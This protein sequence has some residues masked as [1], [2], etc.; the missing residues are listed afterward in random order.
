[1][2]IWNDIRERA[3][4]NVEPTAPPDSSLIT[5]EAGQQPEET[6]NETPVSEPTPFVLFDS[7]PETFEDVSELDWYK[8]RYSEAAQKLSDPQFYDSILERYGE[9]ILKREQEAEEIIASFKALKTNPRDFV[10]QYY[11]ESLAEIGISPVLSPEEMQEKIKSDLASEFGED[12]ESMYDEKDLAPWKGQTFS[13]RI[14]DRGNEL[15]DRYKSENARSQE[16]FDGYAKKVAEGKNPLSDETAKKFIDE[17][18]E[19][20]FKSDGIARSD[21][22]AFVDELKTKELTIRDMWKLRNYESDIEK[23]RKEGL[24]EGRRSVTNDIRRVALPKSPD[25]VK[26]KEA[27]SKQVDDF[28][29]KRQKA[30]DFMIYPY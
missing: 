17:Q 1:M 19:Q 20:H 3:Y 8:Q 2:D 24:E 25:T 7:P 21:Y 6:P 16:I 15:Y 26:P 11:P 29:S 4:N 5:P 27:S 22:D 18:Y 14:Y 30:G 12:Y 10:R 28:V 9:Q 23:A 13:R